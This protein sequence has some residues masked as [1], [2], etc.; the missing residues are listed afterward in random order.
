[1]FQPGQ[2]TTANVR[3]CVVF[4]STQLECKQG[5]PLDHGCLYLLCSLRGCYLGSTSGDRRAWRCSMSAPMPRFYEHLHDIQ[6]VRRSA[7]YAKHLRKTKIFHNIHLGDLAVWVVAVSDLQRVRALEQCHLRIGH[8]PANS[9]STQA[10]SQK[11]TRHSVASRKRNRRPLPRFRRTTELGQQAARHL[12]VVHN[13]AQKIVRIAVDCKDSLQDAKYLQQAFFMP[14]HKA[15]QHVLAH[16][17]ATFGQSGPLDL[18]AACLKPLFACY[19]YSTKDV[20][21]DSI[22]QRWGLGSE[23][24]GC[25]AV[26]ALRTLLAQPSSRLRAKG[27]KACD[28]WLRQHGLPGSKRVK[29]RWPSALPRCVFK[30][31]LEDVRRNLRSVTSPLLSSWWTQ[32]VQAVV[33]R[34]KAY[35]SRW[36]HIQACRNMRDAGLFHMPLEAL[37]L[38]PSDARQMKLCKLYWKTPM[39]EPPRVAAVHAMLSVNKWLQALPRPGGATWKRHI[40]GWLWSRAKSEC[41]DFTQHLAYAE[42]LTVPQGHVAVQ[43][44]KDKAACWI[45]PV[46]VYHKLLVLM[47]NQ[48]KHHWL[49]HKGLICDIIETYRAQHEQ[50]LPPYLQPFALR[51]RWRKWQLPYMYINIKTKCFQSGVGRVC[52]KPSHACCRRVVS[53]AA[54][55]CRWMYKQNA[56]ALEAVVRLWG[57]G[58]ETA[59]LFSA[60]KDLR[61]AVAQ[62]EHQHSFTCACFRCGAPKQPLCAWVGDAAQLFEE[63]SRHEVLHRLRKLITEL[64]NTSNAFGVVT[65]KSRKLHFWFARNNFRPSQGATLHRWDDIITITDLGLGQTCVQVG[66]CVYEQCRGVPIGGFLSKQ[67]ASIFLGVSEQAFVEKLAR[68]ENNGWCPPG[69]SFQNTVAATRYVDDLALVS[70]TLCSACLG[71][72]PGHIYDQPVSF[73]ET[74]PSELGLPWLD[75]WLTCSGS[76]LNVHA[77][78]MEHAWRN[79]AALGRV[80]LPTKFRLMPF[81]GHA[82]LDVSLLSAILNGKLNRL[83]SLDLSANDMKRAVECELQIWLLHGYPLQTILHIWRRGK[84]FPAA[85]THGRE[86]LEHAI[87]NCGPTACV[88]MSC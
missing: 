18:R 35:T 57:K 12:H 77:H 56:K 70:T 36:K 20:S 46:T 33:P 24:A 87:R 7:S 86:V 67:C 54:H 40:Q 69:F 74:K 65:K 80:S 29:I 66:P 1:M 8:W 28:A 49:P 88:P 72:L 37:Q 41:N 26:V 27:V 71:E 31:C 45:M 68:D 15:Y 32:N 78:G 55:P 21:W 5:V 16:R 47:V 2:L 42:K 11:S 6:L 23:P 82:M 14:F 4:L 34:R 25:E 64:Q 3:S 39:L 52:I 83:L 51:S 13:Q 84:R 81:Q 9:Q 19:L 61:G 63:I 22:R 50:Q 17:R 43:E 62:L 59:D 79:E 75:V 85:I 44:D 60:V 73:D 10:P 30:A 76:D 53:W 58:F 38:T 48:D